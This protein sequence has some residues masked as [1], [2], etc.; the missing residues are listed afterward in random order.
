MGSKRASGDVRGSEPAVIRGGSTTAQSVVKALRR[1]GSAIRMLTIAVAGLCAG[2]NSTSPPPNITSAETTTVPASWLMYQA[3]GEHNAIVA[4]PGFEAGWVF[5]A[6]APINGGVALVGDTLVVD[7]FGHKVIALDV[8][9]GKQRWEAALDNVAM[10]SPVIAHGMVYVGTGSNERMRAPTVG[11]P[12]TANSTVENLWGRAEGD[13]IIAL[14]LSDGKRRWTF[15][16]PGED[17]PSPAYVKGMLVFANGDAHAYGLNAR[18]GAMVWKTSLRGISTM[19]SANVVHNRVLLGLCSGAGYAGSTV[20]VDAARGSIVW[21]AAHGDC[22]SSPTVAGRRIFVS[23]APS[24]RVPYGSEYRGEVSALDADTGATLWTYRA[25]TAGPATMVG[26]SERAVAGC[27]ADGMYFQSIPTSN[28]VVAFDAATGRVKWSFHTVA[29]SKMSPIVN[30]HHVFLGDTA[31]ML[32]MLDETTGK[33]A[34]ARPF[35]A[36]FSTAPP[37]LIG[38]TLIVV[39]GSKVYALPQ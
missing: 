5:D 1:G 17:M 8:N 26:S 24:R 27:Y 18:T 32:Y 28:L 25:P 3:N 35:R 21:S 14:D 30:A 36:A 10:S 20:A 12:A 19:A 31:G 4:R 29:P 11:T 34:T 33:L 2:C 23:G 38:S 37:V 7:T 9:Q 6:G 13:G 16:T 22:D 39:A 15:Q